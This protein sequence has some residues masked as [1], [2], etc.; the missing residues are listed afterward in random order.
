M[1]DF[2]LKLNA[3]LPDDVCLSCVAFHETGKD[4]TGEPIGEC[5]PSSPMTVREDGFAVWPM[6]SAWDGCGDWE[7]RK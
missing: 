1:M 4:D 6:V 2:L 7:K 5:R 3:L